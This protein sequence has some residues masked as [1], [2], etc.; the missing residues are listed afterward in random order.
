MYAVSKVSGAAG[1]AGGLDRLATAPAGG[2]GNNPLP[3]LPAADGGPIAF[4]YQLDPP[5][6]PVPAVLVP[7]PEVGSARAFGAAGCWLGQ[8]DVDAAVEFGG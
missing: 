2:A 7:P 5:L 6:V 3:P 4:G 1:A 8:G